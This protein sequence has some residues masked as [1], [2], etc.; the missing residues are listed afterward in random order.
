LTLFKEDIGIFQASRLGLF[1]AVVSP[2]F[3][4]LARFF[5]L[6]IIFAPKNTDDK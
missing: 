3:A 2:P 4:L 1:V 5:S 6:S